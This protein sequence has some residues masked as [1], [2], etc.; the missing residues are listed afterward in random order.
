MVGKSTGCEECA[1]ADEKGWRPEGGRES[2]A[3]MTAGGQ[4]A[5]VASGGRVG[6]RG[7]STLLS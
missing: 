5:A 3:A 1:C 6:R 2:P 7:Q 4:I